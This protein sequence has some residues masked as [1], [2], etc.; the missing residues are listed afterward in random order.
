M[1]V[2]LVIDIENA[3]GPRAEVAAAIGDAGVNIA[4]S[5]SSTGVEQSIFRSRSS[6]SVRLSSSRTRASL[7]TSI[8]ARASQTG[9]ARSTGP[10]RA[11][12]DRL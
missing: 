1:A 11:S 8:E 5:P 10:E 7:S 4:G 9:S 12:G 3:P 2:D 6:C